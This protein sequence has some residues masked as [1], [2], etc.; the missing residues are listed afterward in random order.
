MT[1]F[2]SC[3]R[4]DD[5]AMLLR[6]FCARETAALMVEID[7]IAASA[8]FRTMVT[9]GGQSMSAAMTNCGCVGWVTDRT[10]YRYAPH[11]PT[12]GQPWPAMPEAFKT[13]AARAAEEGGFDSFAPDA[14]LVNRYEPG[15]KMGLHQDKDERDFTQPIVSVSL[16]ASATFLW[17]GIKRSD[18]PRRV[19]LDDGDVV[20]WGGVN[21]LVFHGV[22]P[23]KGGVRYNL[24]FRRAL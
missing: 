3:E 9:P 20:V 13:L 2:A 21:R 7:R 22:A 23:I 10:G 4:I 5:G 17:G 18:K 15:A 16:G 8:P 1:L 19:T 12:T 14:C 24:T 11:D 6:G